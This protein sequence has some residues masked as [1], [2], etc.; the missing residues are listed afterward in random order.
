MPTV[1]TPTVAAAVL[2]ATPGDRITVDA[3]VYRG[4]MQPVTITVDDLEIRGVN[5][6][7][8]LPPVHVSGVGVTLRDLWMSGTVLRVAIPLADLATTVTSEADYE[9]RAVGLDV[10]DGAVD[11]E[12]LRFSRTTGVGLDA[13]GAEVTLKD[14]SFAGF[15]AGPALRCALGSALSWEEGQAVSNQAGALV[16]TDSVASVRDVRF[17]DN[18]GAFGADVAAS[19]AGEAV[20]LERLVARRS[21][22][23]DSGGSVHATGLK[24]T[25]R[26]SQFEDTAAEQDGGA[27]A[28]FGGEAVLVDVS[29]AGA[30]AARGGA[31]A[32]VNGGLAATGLDVTGSAATGDGGALH[33]VA[34]TVSLSGQ[35]V[36]AKA[37]G[38]GGAV[39]AYGGAV[40]LID[41]LAR[42]GEA[43]HG[44]VAYQAWGTLRV[45]ASRLEANHARGAG[46]VHGGEGSVLEVT[47][48]LL[49]ENTAAG[50]A[51]GVYV[52]GGTLDDVITNTVFFGNTASAGATLAVRDDAPPSQDGPRVRVHND[53]FVE[54]AVGVAVV[55]LA[56]TADLSNDL[57]FG[58]APVVALSD[59]ARLTGGWN[60]AF[61]PSGDPPDLGD[62]DAFP[63]GGEVFAGPRFQRYVS[64]DCDAL[65]W[66]GVGSPAR[67]AGDP[68]IV[69]PDGS[70]SD[71]GAFGGPD[72]D[73]RDLD[74][75]GAFEDQ[76]CDESDPDVY[77]GAP[78]IPYDG[79]D[80]SCSGAD[81]VDVDGDGF[82]GIPTPGVRVDCDD[83][84]P[85][86]FPGAPEIPYDGVDQSCSGADL[87]DV[88]GDGFAG[89]QAG[90][91]DCD[92][93]DPAVHPGAEEVWY[94]GVDQDCDGNDSDRDRDGFAAVAAGG[95]DCDDDDP[96]VHPGAPE[97][98][99]DT[100][101][102]DCDGH[103]DTAW[104]VGTGGWWCATGPL[105]G[106]WAWLAILAPLIR[107]R[108]TVRHA[109]TPPAEA[110]PA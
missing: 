34:S 17:E 71:I 28:V 75:D 82:P 90:G 14:V 22:A 98:F 101:D 92:D 31:L 49:C 84:D 80:Q 21:R 63:A 79:I 52:G 18:A 45:R 88:D 13:R 37:G 36:G 40:D 53:T 107:V 103:V 96:T 39:W 35:I 70:R 41:L 51:S 102:R 97:A 26:G 30:A 69:D 62:I 25:V 57:F 64:G 3:S 16:L 87:V 60:L 12:S 4:E 44:A 89:W 94:D 46:A 7:P 55:D 11:G 77:P 78:E 99:G 19:G 93:G 86:A 42:D 20:L 6:E 74:G 68:R 76:D 1:T 95:V 15:T 67:D 9:A 65:L 91:P 104:M 56:G 27:V 58:D 61:D 23:S 43:A 50:E 109:V 24:L 110:P 2:I 66:L 83:E 100:K 81:L 106:A 108:R 5:G 32:V 33:A 54:D 73:L 38:D 10:E 48:S 8:R 72:A 29:V 105:P 85:S 59:D 47:R